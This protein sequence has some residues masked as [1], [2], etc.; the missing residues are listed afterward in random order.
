MQKRTSFA[1]ATRHGCP[2]Q[3]RPLCTGSSSVTPSPSPACGDASVVQMIKFIQSTQFINKDMHMFHRETQTPAMARTS[4]LNEELGQVG[5]Q[6]QGSQGVGGEQGQS[7][8]RERGERPPCVRT[9]CHWVCP[10]PPPPVAIALRPLTEPLPSSSPYPC[11]CGCR[12]GGVHLLGQDGHADA[13]H[14][15]VL[16]VLHRGGAVRN[17]S[18][19]D[20][21]RVGST[22][23]AACGGCKLP[24][25]PL[26]HPHLRSPCLPLTLRLPLLL[27]S[28]SALS[29][30]AFSLLS[31]CFLP[32]AIH[33]HVTGDRR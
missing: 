32:A 3:A 33:L 11:C 6:G 27:S 14:H 26:P 1:S 22:H 15:G 2:P 23:G 29:L 7:G 30:P 31:P 19:R 12:A 21:T 13:Q 10:S 4:N 8:N 16:Q 20:P 24:P 18:H 25:L 17:G 9:G 5:R 28:L